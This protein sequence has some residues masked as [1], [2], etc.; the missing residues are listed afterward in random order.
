MENI[1]AVLEIKFFQIEN[2]QKHSCHHTTPLKSSQEKHRASMRNDKNS[3][4]H[5]RDKSAAGG[6]DHNGSSCWCQVDQPGVSR[7][8]SLV[9]NRYVDVTY[10]V[11]H[12]GGLGSM[13]DRFLEVRIMP[14]AMHNVPLLTVRLCTSDPNKRKLRPAALFSVQSDHLA[15][16]FSSLIVANKRILLRSFFF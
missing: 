4:L 7:H 16:L 6:S 9:G 5:V 2:L 8:V 1:A 11:A 14:V 3:P 15:T 12:S 10:V 13:S